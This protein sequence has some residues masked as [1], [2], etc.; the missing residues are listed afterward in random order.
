M[1]RRN[2]HVLSPVYSFKTIAK[3]IVPVN[4]F[5]S[6]SLGQIHVVKKQFNAQRVQDSIASTSYLYGKFEISQVYDVC[7]IK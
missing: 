4:I 3:Q 5:N 7:D 1:K 6:V 2:I